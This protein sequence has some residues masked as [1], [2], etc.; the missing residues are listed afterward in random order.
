MT[1]GALGSAALSISGT[2]TNPTNSVQ[3]ATYTVT[4]TSGSCSGTTFTVTVTVNPKPAITSMTNTVCSGVA[5]TSTPVNL[6]NGVVPSGTTYSWSAPTVTGGMTGGASGSAAASIS[7]TL[8]NPTNSVQTATF[9]VTPTSGSCSGTTF[10]VTVTVNP[11]PSITAMTNTVCSGVAFTST[12][13]NVTNGV[14]PSGTTYSWSAPT[15]TGGLTGG[16]SG[17]AASSISGTLT[18]P[19]NS[20]QTATYTVTPTLGSC[21]GTTFTVTVTVNPKPSITAMTN[22]VCSGVAFTSTPANVTNGVIPSGT[23]YSWSAPTVTG[24]ITGGASGSAAASISGTLTNPTNNVQTATYT[25]TPTSGSCLGS[26]FT[27]TVTVN[28]KPSITAMTNTACSGVAF[29]STPANATNGLVPSVTTYSWSAPTVTG[30]MTGGASGSAASSISGILTNPT[31]SVQT[32]TYTVTP[33]SGSCSGSTFTVT[34]TVNPK[35]AITSMTNTACS[36]VAFTSTPANATNGLVP[37]VTTYSWSAPTVTGGMTGGASGSAAASISGTLTNPTNSVQTATYTVTPT[38]GSCS[39]TTFTVTV[40]VNPKPAI[41]AMTNTV[42][43]GVVFTSTPVNVTNGVVPSGT[44][45]SWSA[46]T[47][48]GGMTGGASGL[49]A[50]SISGTLTNPTNIVQTATYTVTPTSGF[51]SGTTF[52]VTVTVNPT[53]TFTTASTNPTVCNASDG[54]ITLGGLSPNTSYTYSL[55]GGASIPATTNGSGQIII[56]SLAATTYS[57]SVSNPSTNCASI[58]Q[59]VSLTSPGSPDVNDITDQVLCGGSY[60]LPAISGTNLTGSNPGYYTGPN[61]TGTSLTV[62]ASISTSQ[63]IYVYAS[64]PG[65]CFDQETFTVTINAL[66]TI[67]GTLSVCVGLTTQ[68]TGSG[69]PNATSPWSSASTGVAS[70]SSTGLVTGVSQGTSVITYNDINGCQITATITVNSLPTFTTAFTNPTICNGTNGTIT[71]SGLQNNTNYTYTLNGGSATA[72]TSN[73]SGQ[74]TISSLASGSYLVG[75]TLVSTGCQST[76]QTVTLSN[77]NS[78]DVND[79][80]D[81]V[82]CGG[83][84]TLPTITG[85]LTICGTGT[86]SLTGSG[87]ANATT[88]W[89]S[90]NTAAVNLLTSS[91]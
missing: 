46:P 86:T 81:Q 88:P 3:T 47:V 24:G 9:T 19:T 42:C 73:G 68:L 7:G 11:A 65:G 34:V 85:T 21:S 15:V 83:S 78:P 82:L 72:S 60:T 27:V 57:V 80:T 70:I 48:T 50:A 2:L 49:N 8:T 75:I 51:C 23:T 53:I 33:I 39:G 14:V 90:S 89:T 63:T 13:A 41:T 74:I 45:Y 38:S 54:T 62:G 6:T 76:T 31:N 28:P 55:N 67:S 91:T 1:G 84:Y 10:T 59:N 43:S 66:P 17:S 77:P 87:T 29:T 12:P 40:T 61:G 36:G 64:T 30:G 56:T 32:A 35:P 69:T 58:S 5:F 26:T 22:T 44:T 16:V 25:V 52:T 20:V 37:S 4:P 18:N 71:L 79:I